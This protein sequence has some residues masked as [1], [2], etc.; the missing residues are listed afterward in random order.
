MAW[1]TVVKCAWSDKFRV[2]TAAEL[3]EGLAPPS[4]AVLDEARRRLGDLPGVAESLVWQGVPWRWTFVYADQEHGDARATAYLIPDPQRLQVCVPLNQEQIEQFPL[5]RM[6]NP[7]RDGIVYARNVGGVWWPTWEIP[8]S[9]ALGEVLDL[10]SRKMKV[11]AA[12]QP[13]EA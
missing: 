5:K 8:T 10:L 9:G 3:R 13:V 1:G 4:R 7:I 2:P 12:G 11:V 6:K